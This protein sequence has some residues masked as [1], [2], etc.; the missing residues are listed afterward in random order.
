MPV[1][2]SI[3]RISIT[4][5]NGQ[6]ADLIDPVA[7]ASETLTN[8]GSAVRSTIS[9]PTDSGRYA[10]R[11]RVTDAEVWLKFGDNTVE[12]APNDDFAMAGGEKEYCGGV[13]GQFVSVV[14]A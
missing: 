9:V 13:A 6:A 3:H 1:R 2:L 10:W 5:P 4:Y 12:A 7:V 11:I 14:N 8:G